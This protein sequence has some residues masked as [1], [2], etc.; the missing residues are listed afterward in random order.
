MSFASNLTVRSILVAAQLSSRCGKKKCSFWK[1][2]E[3]TLCLQERHWQSVNSWFIWLILWNC[4]PHHY[5]H[6]YFKWVERGK[7]VGLVSASCSNSWTSHYARALFDTVGC[8]KNSGESWNDPTVPE[9]FLRPKSLHL[10]YEGAK[11]T[12]PEIIMWKETSQL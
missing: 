4:D 1:P 9:T 11:Y 6:H 12:C 3:F 8:P 2:E 10:N 7:G 5:C